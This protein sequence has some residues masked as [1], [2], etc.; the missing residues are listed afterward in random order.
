VGGAIQNSSSTRRLWD[1]KFGI[2]GSHSATAATSPVAT[3]TIPSVS[4][5]E[6]PIPECS[7]DPEEC[8]RRRARMARKK[9]IETGSNTPVLWLSIV[10]VVLRTKPAQYAPGLVRKAVRESTLDGR[11]S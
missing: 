2:Q 9:A 8:L 1:K 10:S 3:P 4:R 6:A 5:R 11:G 7:P